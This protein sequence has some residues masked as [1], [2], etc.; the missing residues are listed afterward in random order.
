MC[1]FNSFNWVPNRVAYCITNVYRQPP[2]KCRSICVVDECT[3]TPK[4]EIQ[5]I[6]I[7]E[8]KIVSLQVLSL[9]STPLFRPLCPLKINHL[10][11]YLFLFVFDHLF[12]FAFNKIFIAH[13]WP[14]RTFSRTYTLKITEVIFRNIGTFTSSHR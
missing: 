5:F 7:K 8:A 6:R 3:T 2:F 4:T 9:Q 11:I 1:V 13:E 12:I 14:W 10:E